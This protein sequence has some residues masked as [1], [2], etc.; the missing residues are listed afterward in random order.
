MTPT[1]GTQAELFQRY[2][3]KAGTLKAMIII[4]P[5]ILSH[6]KLG[7]FF[8]PSPHLRSLSH[9]SHTGPKAIRS[10]RKTDVNLATV[11][12]LV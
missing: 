11:K 3:Q 1:A 10:L 9:N 8:K 2:S 5:D 12:E 6:P 4:K 7:S